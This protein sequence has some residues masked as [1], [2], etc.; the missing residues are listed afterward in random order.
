[1]SKP[2][3]TDHYMQYEQRRYGMD[4]D[5]YSWSMLTE[6]KP[7]KWPGGNKLALWVNVC[8]EFFPLDQKGVPYKVPG[9]MTMPYPDLRHFS[10]RDYGN[11]VGIFRILEALDQYGITPTF[12]INSRMVEQAPYLVKRLAQRG[13]EILCQGW[14]MDTLHW[15]NAT[16]AEANKEADIVAKSLRVLREATGQPVTGW[17]SPAKNQ[18]E[19]T[20]AYLADNGIEY[21]GDW[22]NDDMP[23]PFTCQNKSLLNIPLSTELDDQFILHSNLHSEQSYAEQI[24]D[25]CD[26]LLAEAE[27]Q[28]GRLLA[29]N[30]H[31][32]LLGQ[33]HRIMFFEQV[34]AHI[35]SKTGIWSA[36]AAEICAAFQ[37]QQ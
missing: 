9:G 36:S 8:V 2:A 20:A 5:F 25:A 16:Q 15:G 10:L 26:L 22:V 23:Y 6:R 37:Q 27:E 34:L 30:I 21:C 7:V 33:P 19:L 12:S 18:S 1:M 31:P 14:D 17:L 29:L 32:W 3:L 28:G 24:C 11:R 35:S 13:N 4:H